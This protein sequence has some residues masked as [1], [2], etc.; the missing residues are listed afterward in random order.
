MIS[1]YGS[2]RS[3]LDCYMDAEDHGWR[4]EPETRGV[5]GHWRVA[6]HWHGV[7]GECRGLCVAVR[8]V[9]MSGLCYRVFVDPGLDHGGGRVMEFCFDGGPGDSDRV[10][11][12]MLD[13]WSGWVVVGPA[14]VPVKAAMLEVE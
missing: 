14:G 12:M 6:G 1:K 5:A 7:W 11:R 9:M 13:E 10:L 8:V 4:F 3:F 2:F